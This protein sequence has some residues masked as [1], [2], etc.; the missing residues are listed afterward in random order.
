VKHSVNIN[1][2]VSINYP[3]TSLMQTLG[4]Y[5][6]QDINFGGNTWITAQIWTNGSLNSHGTVTIVGSVASRQSINWDGSINVKF[7]PANGAILPSAWK[8]PAGEK[9]PDLSSY[10]E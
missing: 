7:L 6:E 9:R 2:N 5:T 4:L 3:P 1:G 10:W 8:L